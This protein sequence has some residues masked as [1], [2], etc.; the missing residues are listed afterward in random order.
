MEE[1]A[2][3]E[4]IQELTDLEL[5]LLLGLTAGEHCIIQTEEEV[6]DLAEEELQLV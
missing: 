6:L 3:I 5:A 1:S 4:S 2:L